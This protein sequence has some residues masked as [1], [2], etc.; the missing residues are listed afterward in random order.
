MLLGGKAMKKS[1]YFV[2]IIISILVFSAC[3]VNNKVE[4]TP[5]NTSV[6]KEKN[7]LEF[8]ENLLIDN[9]PVLN[10]SYSDV[11]KNFGKPTN[12][13]TE[14]IL[15]PA[16]S[17]QDYY[18]VNIISYD[19]IDFEFELGQ[20][21]SMKSIEECKVWRFDITGD[22]YNIGHLKVGMSI[23][24]Y[25]VKFTDSKIYPLSYLLDTDT[26]KLLDKDYYAYACLQRLLITSKPKDYYSIYQNVS[27]QQGVLVNKYGESIAPLGFVILIKDNKID[28]IVYGF[29]NAG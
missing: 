20:N 11:I 4:K 2:I 17:S 24:D 8:K 13:R 10:M 25:Q 29:P 18:Y 14:K 15:F 19:G 3:S 22:K 12:I 1:V 26:D 16:S 21:K 5:N 7:S 6:E 27:Y 23:E 28:R 9:K